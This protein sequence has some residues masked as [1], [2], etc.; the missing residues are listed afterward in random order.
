MNSCS[1]N[2]KA[3]E[4]IKKYNLEISGLLAPGVITVSGRKNDITNFVKEFN[5]LFKTKNIASSG[6]A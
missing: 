5:V 6:Q 3:I 2:D 4:L 1:S